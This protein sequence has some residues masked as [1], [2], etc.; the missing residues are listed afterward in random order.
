M[1]TALLPGSYDPITNGHLEIIKRAALLYDKVVVLSAVNPDKK[2][3]LSD[4]DRLALI[5]DAIKEIPQAV[6]DSF[7]GFLVD[8]C[9][10]HSISV[11]VKGLRNGDDFIYEKKMAV[12]NKELGLSKYGINVETVFMCAEDKFSETSSSVVRTHIKDGTSFDSLVPNPQ[13]LQKLLNK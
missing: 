1:R 5:K 11:I 13:L 4:D 6:A 8:Y 10:E 9:K 12:F 2:Y 3:L 7:P